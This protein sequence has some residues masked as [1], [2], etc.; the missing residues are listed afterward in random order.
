MMP[1]RALVLEADTDRPRSGATGRLNHAYFVFGVAGT[2]RNNYR[3]CLSATAVGHLAGEI[4]EYWRRMA[5]M[6]APVTL[7]HGMGRESD[8]REHAQLMP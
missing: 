3:P 6:C 7:R 2:L 5:T 8:H 4:D 1:D